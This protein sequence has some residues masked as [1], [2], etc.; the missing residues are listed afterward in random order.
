MHPWRS[1][2]CW[3]STRMAPLANAVVVRRARNHAPVAGRSRSHHLR[4]FFRKAPFRNDARS[5]LFVKVA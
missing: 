4:P 3:F 1:N 5:R 2:G